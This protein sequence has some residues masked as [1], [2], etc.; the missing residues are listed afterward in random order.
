MR[1]PIIAALPPV[2]A[3]FISD[4]AATT[5]SPS[6]VPD[7]ARDRLDHPLAAAIR[8]IYAAR[9]TWPSVMRASV[10]PVKIVREFS[11]PLHRSSIGLPLRRPVGP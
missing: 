4:S 3:G 7:L 10:G 2:A 6:G 1:R 5:P 9:P 8:L 11:A